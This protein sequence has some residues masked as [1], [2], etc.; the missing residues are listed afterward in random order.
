MTS[1]EREALTA[2]LAD[3]Y[4]VERELGRGGMATVYL[5]VIFYEMVMGAHPF[6][7]RT[8]RAIATAHLTET[9]ASIVERRKDVPPALATIVMQLLAKDPAARRQSAN[10]VI[11]VL[12]GITTTSMEVVRGRR[13]TRAGIAIAGTLLIVATLGA[14]SWW[15]G[16]TPVAVPARRRFTRWRYCRSSTRAARPTRTTSATG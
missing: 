7:G 12:D 4:T 1:P 15:R 6:A 8:A 5:G 16:K 10:D 2:T 9:P 11:R 3:R 14:Y 13:G